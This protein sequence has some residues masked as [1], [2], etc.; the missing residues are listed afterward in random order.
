[1]VCGSLLRR[2]INSR[3]NKGL[4]SDLGSNAD[5]LMLPVGKSHHL[6]EPWFSHL[7]HGDNNNSNNNSTSYAGLLCESNGIMYLNTWHNVW[8]TVG[9]Q[10]DLGSNPGLLLFVCPGASLP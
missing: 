4:V 5:I 2:F 7:S 9:T 8:Y 6:S 10:L 1:M 3:K